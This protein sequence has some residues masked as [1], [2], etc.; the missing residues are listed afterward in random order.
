[1]RRIGVL[2]LYEEQNAQ[3]QSLL[4]AFQRSLVDRGWVAGRNIM[5]EKRWAG[6]DPSRVDQGA[7]ELVAIQ[8]ELIISSSSPTTIALLRV[9]HPFPSYSFKLSIR[10]VRVLLRA[11]RISRLRKGTTEK[12]RPA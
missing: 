5:F 6:T 11:C 3:A 7:K 9:T 4:A 12:I 1:V 2:M 10:R 8:P